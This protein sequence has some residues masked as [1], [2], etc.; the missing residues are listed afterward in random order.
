MVERCKARA[1]PAPVGAYEQGGGVSYLH[2]PLLRARMGIRRQ[3]QLLEGHAH[4][5]YQNRRS[6]LGGGS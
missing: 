6:W 2:D 3:F 4:T 1:R 5:P